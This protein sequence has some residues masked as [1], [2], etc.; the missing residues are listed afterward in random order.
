MWEWSATGWVSLGKKKKKKRNEGAVAERLDSRRHTPVCSGR[1]G[2]ELVGESVS[3]R[4]GALGDAAWPVHVWAEDLVD[5]M[6]VQAG[7]LVAELVVDIDHDGVTDCGLDGWTGPFVVY[8][9]DGSGETIRVRPY[10]R[11]VPVVS[12]GRAPNKVG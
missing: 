11:H 9:N 6:E 12:D 5:A 7:S 3:R 8:P 2:D 10:P 1:V 4:Q